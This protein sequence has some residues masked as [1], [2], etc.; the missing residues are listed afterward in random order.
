MHH[1]KSNTEIL[2][3]AH[4]N[5][6]MKKSRTEGT[7]KLSDFY[8]AFS[9]VL[10]HPSP[11]AVGGM[12]VRFLLTYVNVFI[13]GGWRVGRGCQVTN[14]RPKIQIGTFVGG[15]GGMFIGTRSSELRESYYGA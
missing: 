2:N 7:S 15:G 1:A 9:D 3:V 14:S 13:E 12:D 6:S 10:K 5:K 11:V 8:S 4:T